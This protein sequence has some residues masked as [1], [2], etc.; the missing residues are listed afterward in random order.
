MA[1]SGYTAFAFTAGEIP[2]TAQWNLIP[3]ND[4]SFNN[5]NGF[6]DN[7]IVT[8]HFATS[9][10]QIVDKT[11][12]PYKFFAYASGTTAMTSST[13]TKAAIDTNTGVGFDTS[14]GFN[15]SLNRYVI[16]VSGYWFI[17]GQVG[18]TIAGSSTGAQQGSLYKNGSPFVVGTINPASGSATEINRPNMSIFIRL[19]VGDYIEVYG[20]CGESS[21]AMDSGS[22]TTYLC[23]FL[24]SAT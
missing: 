12:N 5:G 6:N 10:L 24:V 23:G 21:R 18:V 4:A 3:Y 15:T 14:S 8:R 9:G 20:W 1:S 16:P 2:T 17:N 11:I 7:I 13:W 19:T 22:T